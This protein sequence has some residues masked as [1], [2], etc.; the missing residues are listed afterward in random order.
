MHPEALVNDS[1]HRPYT[2]DWGRIELITVAKAREIAVALAEAADRA[3]EVEAD[4]N[5]GR[6]PLPEHPWTRSVSLHR[7]GLGPG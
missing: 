6:T 4:P 2:E 3:E 5:C 1:A 7:L